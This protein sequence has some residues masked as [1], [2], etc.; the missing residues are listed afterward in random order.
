MLLAIADF[1]HA[2]SG[3]GASGCI[4]TASALFVMH[5]PTNTYHLS[6]MKGILKLLYGK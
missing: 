2:K 3:N 6:I 4:D 1:V 5:N